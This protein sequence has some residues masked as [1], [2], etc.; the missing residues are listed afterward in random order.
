VI[1]SLNVVPFYH[2]AWGNVWE[3]SFNLNN[4]EYYP[5]VLEKA[6]WGWVA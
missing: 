1:K 2:L 6:G 4:R 3:K 5:V